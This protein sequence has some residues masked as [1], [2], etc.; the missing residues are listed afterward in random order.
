MSRLLGPAVVVLLGATAC[1]RAPLVSAIPIEGC[2]EAWCATAHVESDGTIEV[3]LVVPRNAGRTVE[4]RFVEGVLGRGY[5][6]R[7][8]RLLDG[9]RERPWP[10][11][12]T[13]PRGGRTLRYRVRV[14]TPDGAPRTMR[15]Q[16]FPH[17]AGWHLKGYSFLPEHVNGPTQPPPALLRFA[18]ADDDRA[19]GSVVSTE[20]NFHGR[21]L[22]E[23]VRAMYEV[24]RP[25]H[26]CHRTERGVVCVASST[27]EH[28]TRSAR[29][30]RR[31]MQ[32][33]ADLLGPLEEPSVLV[34]IH[35]AATP[36]PL[37]LAVGA[38]VLVLADS[39]PED[40]SPTSFALVHEVVHLW[41]PGKRRVSSLWLR[42][43]LTEYF[44]HRVIEKMSGDEAFLA[45]VLEAHRRH[46]RTGASF[47][48]ARGEDIYAAGIMAGYCLDRLLEPAG[49][50]TAEVVRRLLAQ[51]PANDATPLTDD[52]FF[53]ELAKTSASSAGY[54]RLMMQEPNFDFLRCVTTS[55]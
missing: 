35:P 26:H 46:E 12:F 2:R 40:T 45:R 16:S 4:L 28:L 37:G 47:E 48:G 7:N 29:F 8:V 33:T 39:P 30:V 18:L 50:S 49:T 53:A 31:A 44:A 23:L 22:S 6:D 9:D 25:F 11:E 17:A 27:E 1:S 24:G 15:E 20:R 54:F 34:A 14:P 10:R 3:A 21:H 43:G 42:E 36:M 32:K 38:G 55:L 13:I 52:W 41:N 19:L 51:V 5:T